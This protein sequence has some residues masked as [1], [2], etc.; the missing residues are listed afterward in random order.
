MLELL[1][2][3]VW[4][5]RGADDDKLGE[6]RPAAT[7]MSVE[8]ALECCG[9]PIRDSGAFGA[10]GIRELGCREPGKCKPGC[11]DMCNGSG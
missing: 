4:S 1:E 6:R 9:G 8:R 5:S 7:S 2:D 11:G 3:A 10:P